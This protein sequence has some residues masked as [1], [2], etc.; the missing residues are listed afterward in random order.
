MQLTEMHGLIREGIGK[1]QQKMAYAG[2]VRIRVH[3]MM[4][5]TLG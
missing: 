3:W 1:V 4:P 5:T 2:I